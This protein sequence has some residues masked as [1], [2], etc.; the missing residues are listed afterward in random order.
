MG[1]GIVVHAPNPESLVAVFERDGDPR[2]LCETFVKMSQRN[3]REVVDLPRGG[4]IR[5]LR[6]MVDFARARRRS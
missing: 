2:K 5:N 4:S 3:L 1:R 6:E